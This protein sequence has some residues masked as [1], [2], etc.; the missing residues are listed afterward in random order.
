M[1]DNFILTDK[2]E[3]IKPLQPKGPVPAGV[4]FGRDIDTGYPVEYNTN[5]FLFQDP[6]VMQ[7]KIAQER[8]LGNTLSKAGF[9]QFQADQKTQSQKQAVLG[10]VLTSPSV[11]PVV[12]RRVNV[13]QR[14]SQ[15]IAN[16]L[17][18][19]TLLL[20][21][22]GKIT[23]SA[24]YSKSLGFAISRDPNPVQRAREVYREPLISFSG[25]APRGKVGSRSSLFDY[26]VRSNRTAFIKQ[27][28]SQRQSLSSLFGFTS[29]SKSRRNKPL[30]FW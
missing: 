2:G 15:Q 1:V 28:Q 21:G 25:V 3:V 13:P 16:V 9:Y 10:T 4:G 27:S 7:V 22:V 18:S 17:T 29:G 26:P 12:V 24:G 19:Q 20:S 11:S 23:K 14:D 6:D 5:K 8:F 30:S